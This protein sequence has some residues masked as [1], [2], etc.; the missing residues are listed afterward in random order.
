MPF[1]S[2]TEPQTG[3]PVDSRENMLVVGE[4]RFADGYVARA[5]KAA[6]H[7]SGGRPFSSFAGAAWHAFRTSP[8]YESIARVEI[9][10]NE[11]ASSDK[12]RRSWMNRKNASAAIGSDRPGR[13]TRCCF[14]LPRIFNLI[15]L[16]GASGKG[17][18]RRASAE[19]SPT[20]APCHDRDHPGRIVAFAIIPR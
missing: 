1:E 2:Q 8:V 9:Q 6:L 3:R 5:H 17:P 10:P 16:V 15:G 7:H 18:D 19:K 14:R 12:A 11:P 4:R 20:G 13:A